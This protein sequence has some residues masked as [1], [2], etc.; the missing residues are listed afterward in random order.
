MQLIQDCQDNV[1]VIGISVKQWVHTF[2]LTLYFEYQCRSIQSIA[3][4]KMSML[5]NVLSNLMSKI[6]TC[7]HVYG[8][9]LLYVYLNWIVQLWTVWCH[10]PYLLETISNKLLTYILNHLV[11]VLNTYYYSLYCFYINCLLLSLIH[12][13]RPELTIPIFLILISTSI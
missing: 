13:N 4:N 6:H 2:Y 9:Y 12:V 7:G 3:A 1:N 5:Y 10:L 11:N 8:R